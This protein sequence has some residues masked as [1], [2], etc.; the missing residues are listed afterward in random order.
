MQRLA[1]HS[2]NSTVACT[3]AQLLGNTLCAGLD[4]LC[5]ALPPPCSTQVPLFD[6]LSLHW[7]LQMAVDVIA[8]IVHP[9]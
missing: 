8:G 1:S 6:H 2:L 7:Q 4:V 3:T 9:G 5:C